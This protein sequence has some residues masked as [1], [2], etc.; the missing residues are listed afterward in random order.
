MTKQKEQRARAANLADKYISRDGTEPSNVISLTTSGHELP[1]EEHV[2]ELHV[3][4]PYW[5][6]GFYLEASGIYYQKPGSA[7]E[8]QFI[9][10][11]LD[12]IGRVRDPDSNGWAR[13]LRWLDPDLCEH[14]TPVSDAKL[15]GDVSVL[16]G[17]LSDQGLKISTASNARRLFLEL[18]NNTH[19]EKNFTVVKKT[20]WHTI[21]G[22]DVFVLPD[23][24]AGADN[25]I[26]ARSL[27]H[28][29]RSQGSLA[30]WKSTVA[31]AA[32][33]N[34][35]LILAISTALAPPLLG[36]CGFEPGGVHLRGQS[37][38]GKTTSL[39]VAAS[40]WG[41]PP[42]EYIKAWR[43]TSNG[44]EGVAAAHCDSL[45]ILDELSQVSP[46]EAGEIAYM[47]A[48]GA[49]KARANREGGT[50]A[51]AQWRLLFLSSGELS[52]AEKVAEDGR[53]KR[54]TAGQQVR[55]IDVPSDAGPDGVFESLH[56]KTGQEFADYLSAV[57][58][59]NYGTAAPL[60][61]EKVRG[62]EGI[63]KTLVEQIHAD[64]LKGIGEVHGQVA[65]VAHRF[66]IAAA[67]GELG[68]RF[69][70]LPW[71]D[72]ADIEGVGKCFTAWFQAW[73]GPGAIELRRGVEQV[74][75]FFELHGDARFGSFYATPDDRPVHNRA[76]FRKTTGERCEWFVLPKVWREEVCRGF[77]T[78]SLNRELI[79]LGILIP[80]G[81]PK[82]A[83]SPHRIAALGSVVKKLY[84]VSD[85]VIESDA[86]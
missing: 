44:L 83:T 75:L 13:L 45:L 38:T 54:A 23:G 14:T 5:P 41:G 85:A 66:A 58:A 29:C 4:K 50:R 11:P 46:K 26:L 1:A 57:V 84:H 56:G 40:V 43:A 28:A 80:Y 2:E 79:R 82:K 21:G 39:R 81:S 30:D 17:E 64:F 73:G 24:T 12:I 55:I 72:G 34:S 9:C 68:I 69:D 78:A 62:Q 33:G 10:T 61:I 27:D 8:P 60:F 18:L 20:G 76:G 15:H 53:G 3:E 47:L 49:G 67:A 71:P 86:D 48:N 51:I 77:D 59:E 65:R 32:I 70:I 6:D 22:K 7:K 37:S 63:A 25:V 52:L 36:L 42:K 19:P 16:C 35:R 31:A 74:R